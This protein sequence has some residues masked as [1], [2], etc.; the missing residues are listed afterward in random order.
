METEEL[1]VE[2]LDQLG[3]KA[4]PV[5]VGHD[6]GTDLI[7][8]LDGFRIPVGV[9]R[10]ALV[11][12][13]VVEGLLAGTVRNE[14]LIVVADRV[15]ETARRLLTSSQRGGYLD[16]RGHLG[17]RA[18]RI[19]I[20]ADVSPLKGRAERANALSGKVGLEVATALLMQPKRAVAVRELSRELA[21]SASTVSEVLSGLRRD[22]LVD[23]KNAVVDARL[24]WEVADKW[25]STRTYL[26]EA[27]R[28]NDA[29]AKSL[30]LW[31]DAV[32]Y[33]AG[34]ALTDSV[35]AAAYQA[36]V[37]IRSEQLL[38]FY[39]P[40]QT[41][42]RRAITL[43]G[44]A[45]SAASARCSVRVA[46]VPAICQHRV[47]VDTNSTEWPLAHPLFVALDLAQDVGRG[48]EIL[49][50]WTPDNRWPRVW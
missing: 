33:E 1:L 32:G 50:A 2:A 47:D 41:L 44:A 39:V 15:T 38:D 17:L 23:E 21:R 28:P 16:L 25:Q 18:D 19:L 26:A 8:D 9:K 24:F 4:W 36:P 29:T 48:R 20:D 42:V 35:A 37:A 14:V 46:P 5:V 43:L 27:P 3:V 30:H 13:S 34:W 40:H 12:D 49:E 22:G 31:I 10:R 45:G 11:T 6:Q 7:L